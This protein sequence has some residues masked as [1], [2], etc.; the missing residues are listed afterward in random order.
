MALEYIDEC[1]TLKTEEA[2]REFVRYMNDPHD[3]TDEGAA[4]L[5]R[6]REL[7]ETIT[8]FDRFMV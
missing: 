3:I 4:L 2:I 1:S 5:S 8:N 7:A 6:A